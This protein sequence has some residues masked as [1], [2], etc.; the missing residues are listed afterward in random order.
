MRNWAAVLVGM[1]CA[2]WAPALSAAKATSADSESELGKRAENPIEDMV[3]VPVELNLD[4][5]IGAYDRANSTLKVEPR[6]PFHVLENWNVAT[7][8][9][10]PI[11]NQA[12]DK[13]TTGGS[14][15]LGDVNPSFFFSP[16]HPGVFAWGVGPDFVLPTATQTGLGAG[17]WSAGPALALVLRWKPFSVATIVSNVWSFAGQSGASSVNKGSLQYFLH[18]DLG[19]GW[20]LKSSPTMTADWNKAT[21]DVWEVPVG[22]GVARAYKW[23]GVAIKPALSAYDYVMR[24]SS[25]PVW[26]LR[27]EVSFVF[28]Q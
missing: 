8:T 23:H 14:S 22:G 13:A 15:G 24:R 28:P 27:A 25:S 21:G 1:S 5:G 3:N 17:K 19:D 26:E 7:R 9:I 11:V 18:L 16:A 6:V 20:S 12:N 4:Y 10:I 2:T